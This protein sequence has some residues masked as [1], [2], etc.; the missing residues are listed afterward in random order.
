MT[1]PQLLLTLL[2]A[3]AIAGSGCS[4]ET[5][6]EGG[7]DTTA[8]G[9]APADTG[10]FRFTGDFQG[11]L[12]IQLYSVRDAMADDVPGTLARVAAL[13]VREVELAG[14]YG[15]TPQ[16]FRQELDRAGLRATSMHA[17][18]DRMRDSLQAVLQEAKT[19]GVQYV[20]VAWVPHEGHFTEEVAR[21][22]AADFNRWGQAAKEQ[23]LTFFY[24]NHG[25]E[26]RPTA[27]GVIPFDVLVSETDAETVKYEMDTFWTVH[28]GVDPVALLRKYPDRWKLMH[29]KDIKRGYPTGDFSGSAPA[30]EAEVPAGQGQ[31]D[32]PALLAAAKEVGVE[33]YYIEDETSDPLGSIAQSAEYLQSLKF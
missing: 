3:L 23:G 17:G 24:H 15:L 2:P 19:L 27:S 10:G 26:F 6:P 13:G 22:T 12:G 4:P 5:A 7:T 28:P 8:E 14:T 32:W 21:R 31:I 9:A 18:Y 25:Y 29:I 20:G 33:H 16:Q 1:R 11:P 30:D